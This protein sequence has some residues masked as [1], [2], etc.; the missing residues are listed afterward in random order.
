MVLTAWGSDVY[1]APRE[2]RLVGQL[3][4]WAARSADWL[5]CDSEDQAQTLRLWTRREDRV[6][7]IG[8]GVDR[9]EFHP[10][11]D[12]TAMRRSLDIPDGAS[13]VLSPRQWLANSN[14][15]TIVAAHAELPETVHLVLKRLPRFEDRGA[16]SVESAIA[17]SPARSRI[18]VVGEMDMSELPS[19]YAA[20]DAVV[21]LCSTDG[22]P[23]SL[24]EAMAVGK[25]VVALRIASV[26][27][28][29]SEPGGHL[30]ERLDPSEVASALSKALRPG[31][32]RA[33]AQAHNVTIVANEPTAT[34]S[35]EGCRRSMRRSPIPSCSPC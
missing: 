8:W 5:T 16:E 21:S 30:I 11:T 23:V 32:A 25:P 13:L 17:R 9:A 26:A 2:S 19:L 24:L 7:V 1:R 14:I 18:R 35:S 28:W 34:P 22:T 29:L 15:S 27:E 4:P 20:A 12:G 31:P 6:S 33:A 10:G 3:N